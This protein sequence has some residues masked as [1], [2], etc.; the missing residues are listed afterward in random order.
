MED[1]GGS[2]GRTPGVD[3]FGVL[4]NDDRPRGSLEKVVR[5]ATSK[6]KQDRTKDRPRH[7]SLPAGG[8]QRERL[9]VRSRGAAS[10]HPWRSEVRK[11]SKLKITMTVKD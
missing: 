7:C 11:Q 10:T 1:E 4:V 8:H 3:P 5:P 6:T 9:R 2:F